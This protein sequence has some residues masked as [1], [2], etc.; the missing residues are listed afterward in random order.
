MKSVTFHVLDGVDKGRVFRELP[1]PVTIG[2]EEGNLL[3]LNDE[4]ISRFHAKVQYDGGDIIITDLES[5]N[6]TRVNGNPISIRRLRAG[7]QVGLGRS[8]LLFGTY[9]EIRTRNAEL[10]ALARQ[11][12]AATSQPGT[13][14]GDMAVPEFDFDLAPDILVPPHENMWLPVDHSLPPM[15]KKLSP[16]QA[17]RLAEIIDYLHRGLTSAIEYVQIAPEG[18]AARLAYADWQKIL[19]VQSLLARYLRAV[20]EPEATL[21]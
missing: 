6:G 21:E 10:V 13:V 11:P 1:V 9:E 5:T 4:R 7:D 18:T 3:R 20:A 2:R 17:A 16:A 19:A 8:T 12:T 15:P 14:L